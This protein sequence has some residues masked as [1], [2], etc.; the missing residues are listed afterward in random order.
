MVDLNAAPAPMSVMEGD[1][2]ARR[3]AEELP[4][5]MSPAGTYNYLGELLDKRRLVYGVPDQVFKRA[6]TFDSVLV[7]QLNDNPDDEHYE[8]TM[9]VKPVQADRREKEE[10]PRGLLVGAGLESLDTL[11]S[12]GVD[13]G[14]IVN[15]IRQAP[16]RMKVATVA[17]FDL[18][19][20]LLRAGDIKGSED[21]GRLLREG[22]LQIVCRF[23]KGVRVHYYVI[24]G[25]I[26]D[27]VSTFVPEDY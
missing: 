8:G 10:A 16:W 12:N 6:M 9:I 1:Q 2:K 22:K 17:G 18:W 27:P 23:E 26:W 14:H 7:W 15:F 3:I 21:T 5:H 13:L 25:E 4:R 20:L 19:C 11:R 24:D